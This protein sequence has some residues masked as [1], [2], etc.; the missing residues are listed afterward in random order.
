MTG[1]WVVIR[2]YPGTI[3]AESDR[4]VLEASGI[5]AHVLVDDA[6]GMLPSLTVLLAAKLA[7]RE[8]D[9]EEALAV[10]DGEEADD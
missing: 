1:P 9:A 3:E 8:G 2:T 5:A 7:V 4:A 6:G 10:L